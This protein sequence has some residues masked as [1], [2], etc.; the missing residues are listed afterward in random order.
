MPTFGRLRPGGFQSALHELGQRGACAPI[1]H[2]AELDA[3][4]VEQIAD[5][6]IHPA[7]LPLDD[8]RRLADGHRIDRVA[9][10]QCGGIANRHER[11]TELMGGSG[12]ELL[13]DAAWNSSGGCHDRLHS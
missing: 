4:K 11:V 1:L 8:L 12:D 9:P 7:R 5:E 6:T 10:Q 2:A 3:R 13:P